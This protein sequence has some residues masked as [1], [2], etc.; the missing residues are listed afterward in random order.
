[1]PIF[2]DCLFIGKVV[3]WQRPWPCQ[4]ALWD[5]C[6]VTSRLLLTVKVVFL[7]FN[8]RLNAFLIYYKLG[9]YDSH[10][11]N[12]IAFNLIC[13]LLPVSYMFIEISLLFVVDVLCFGNVFFG[14]PAAW[15]FF[16][17]ERIRDSRRHVNVS[18]RVAGFLPVFLQLPASQQNCGMR[19]LAEYKKNP[20]KAVRDFHFVFPKE[21]VAFR[22]TAYDFC[23]F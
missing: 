2:G 9:K 18:S 4:V 12:L 3:Y 1:M 15:R 21:Q 22:F 5:N 23:L 10:V 7:V 13:V 8:T 16:Y 14:E 17:P 19:G 6:K 11:R 20:A